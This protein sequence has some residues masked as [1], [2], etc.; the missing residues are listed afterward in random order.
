MENSFQ[1][2]EEAKSPK[3]YANFSENRS[4]DEPALEVL[5]I[6]LFQPFRNKRLCRKG[7]VS[8]KENWRLL[9]FGR[10][11]IGDGRNG[12]CFGLGFFRH[13]IHIRK[14]IFEQHAGVVHKSQKT[15]HAG[16]PRIRDIIV[17]LSCIAPNQQVSN[18]AG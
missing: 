13:A 11:R 15:I 1:N 18:A 4:R 9:L 12:W 8:I 5:M 17:V 6:V 16:M 7:S 10:I 2:M 14:V 3:L